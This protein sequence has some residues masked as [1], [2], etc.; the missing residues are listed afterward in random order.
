MTSYENVMGLEGLLDPR[1]EIRLIEDP[2]A[3]NKLS[4]TAQESPCMAWVYIPSVQLKTKLKNGSLSVKPK[5]LFPG[6]VFLRCVMNKELHDFIRECDGVGGFVGSKVGN[7]KRQINKPRPVDADDMEAIFKQAKE[8]QEKADQAF[9]E[10][11]KLKLW[12]PINWTTAG[13]SKTLKPGSTVQVV[14]GAFAGFSGTL[15][16]LD[17]K[18]GLCL[19]LV[20]DVLMEFHPLA[21]I[22]DVSWRYLEN[23]QCTGTLDV[24]ANLPLQNLNIENNHFTGWIPEQ[25]KGINLNNLAG[26]GFNGGLPCSISLMTSLKHLYLQNNQFTGTLDVLANL[27]LENLNIENNHFTGWIP[28]QLKGINL[29]ILAGNGF[30]DT[31]I[32]ISLVPGGKHALILCKDFVQHDVYVERLALQSSVF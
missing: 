4:R 30:T 21:I 31:L 15:K 19:I 29:N 8:E 28:E 10:Q 16:K 14:S 22:G 18:T 1:L 12:I 13:K 23:N 27:P 11:Q 17:M 20:F 24:L 26:N 2:R 6:C 7:T 9:E 32:E 5:S 25:L 3:V